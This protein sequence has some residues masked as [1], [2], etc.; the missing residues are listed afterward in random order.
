MFYHRSLTRLYIRLCNDSSSIRCILKNNICRVFG[1]MSDNLKLLP[2]EVNW[3]LLS[4]RL[5]NEACN[6]VW[7]RKKIASA[8]YSFIVFTCHLCSDTNR[9]VNIYWSLVSVWLQL[10]LF[11]LTVI[12]AKL[13][14]SKRS[15]QFIFYF[16]LCP[17]VLWGERKR[18]IVN[19]KNKNKKKENVAKTRRIP[20][21]I[22]QK[23]KVFFS[24]KRFKKMPIWL[25]LEDFSPGVLTENSTV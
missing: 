25:T 24:R 11:K 22:W 5:Y 13:I 16:V 2:Y 20:Q 10:H 17:H 15:M 9:A 3:Q 6:F 18:K 1:L 14:T 7:E 4:W 23:S 19:S 21:P 12:I 8:E